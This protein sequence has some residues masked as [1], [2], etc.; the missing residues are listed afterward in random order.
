MGMVELSLTEAAYTI[1]VGLVLFLGSLAAAYPFAPGLFGRISGPLSTCTQSYFWPL[2][3]CIMIL[4]FLFGMVAENLS[5]AYTNKLESK[6]RAQTL[7]SEDGT[8]E[9]LGRELYDHGQLQRHGLS[10]VRD[11]VSLAGVV[12]SLYFHAKNTVYRESNYF[13]ELSLIQAR[14]NFIRS[15]AMMS[16]VFFFVSLAGG[17]RILLVTFFVASNPP[18]ARSTVISS[19]AFPLLSVGL[20]FAA[21]AIFAAEETAFNER[22][23]GYY[24]TMVADD[25]YPSRSTNGNRAPERLTGVTRWRGNYIGVVRDRS[26]R[27]P[28]LYN[29]ETNMGQQRL[30]PA[31]VTSRYSNHPARGVE[32]LCATRDTTGHDDAIWLLEGGYRPDPIANP[33]EPARVVQLVLAPDQP[34]TQFVYT[35]HYTVPTRVRDVVGMYCWRGEDGVL[36]F[37]IAGGRDRA[38]QKLHLWRL[39]MDSEKLVVVDSPVELEGIEASSQPDSNCQDPSTIEDPSTCHVPRVTAITGQY[40]QHARRHWIWATATMGE[41]AASSSFVYRTGWIHDSDSDERDFSSKPVTC[42]T[43]AAVRATGISTTAH[44]SDLLLITDKPSISAPAIILNG[45]T[46]VEER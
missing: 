28:Q 26:N 24:S 8:L 41:G 17:L 27:F 31:T 38:T 34:T 25:A 42:K 16:V 13:Q 32:S 18:P 46:Y 22:V 4:G 40:S 30:Y 2:A 14:I 29:L 6:L 44:P 3:I 10:G 20:F 45:C 15:F 37:V 23:F 7:L 35:K 9:S 36:R 33:R 12:D 11:G 19:I 1:A 5:G 21:K 43:M 39:D